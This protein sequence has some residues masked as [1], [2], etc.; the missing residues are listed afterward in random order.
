MPMACFCQFYEPQKKYDH[1]LNES[2]IAGV[3]LYSSVA[4]LHRP[5][6]LMLAFYQNSQKTSVY[7]MISLD[8]M[9]RLISSTK[10]EL[11]HTIVGCK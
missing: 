11:T 4:I 8:L 10:T 6:C 7:F 9:I 5:L 3:H 1:F 2:P